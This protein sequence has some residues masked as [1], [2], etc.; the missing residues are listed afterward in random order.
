MMQ[1]GAFNIARKSKSVR[2]KH[3]AKELMLHFAR[4]KIDPL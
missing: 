2:K 1:W 3:D 4:K